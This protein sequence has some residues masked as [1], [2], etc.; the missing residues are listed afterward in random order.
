MEISK[1]LSTKSTAEILDRLRLYGSNLKYLTKDQQ[2]EK[3]FVIEAVKSNGKALFHASN[4][5]KD[6]QEVVLEAVKKDGESLKFVSSRLKK[7]KEICFL[8]VSSAPKAFKDLPKIFKENKDFIMEL[9]K[10]NGD[11]VSEIFQYL[12]TNIKKEFELIQQFMRK[13]KGNSNN[14]IHRKRRGMCR[15]IVMRERSPFSFPREFRRSPSPCRRSPSPYQELE[16]Y[17]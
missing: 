13:R 16:V 11:G 15:E 6:D 10:V 8:A 17:E 4:T 7:N 14:N 2:N 1:T 12:P 5:L 9:I 3:Q